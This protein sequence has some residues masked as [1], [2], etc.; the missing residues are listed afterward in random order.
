MGGQKGDFGVIV[1]KNG[2]FDVQ[3]TVKLPGGRIGH[4]GKVVSGSIAKGETATL[5]VSALN[6]SL[7]HI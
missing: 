6:L 2:T 3:E 7:I 1:T 4:I 5:E